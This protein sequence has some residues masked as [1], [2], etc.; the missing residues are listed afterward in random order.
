[1]SGRWDTSEDTVGVRLPALRSP[2]FRLFWFGQMISLTG[3]WVQSVAQ[4]WLV[5]ELTHSAFQL[6][7]V[8]TI[9]FTPLL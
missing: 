4:Q 5:L 6:G 9:Q 2:E 7:L 3:T 1:M 8:T